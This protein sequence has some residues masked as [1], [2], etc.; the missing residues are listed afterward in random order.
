MFESFP[1]TRPELPKEFKDLYAKHYK[2]NRDGDTTAA[3][4]AQKMES[5]L[6]KKVA[7]NENSNL[8]TESPQNTFKESLSK[9]SLDNWS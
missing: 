5:W 3:S 2:S 9:L 7:S 6:H 4:L 8:L 1:K